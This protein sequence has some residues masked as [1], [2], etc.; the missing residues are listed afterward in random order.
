MKYTRYLR[1]ERAIAASDRGGIIE[2]WR[3]GTRV[4]NDPKM[5]TPNGNLRHGKLAELTAEAKADGHDAA[6]REFQRRLQCARAYRSDAEIR[7]AA[8][9]FP[10]WSDLYDAGFPPVQV[11]LDADTEPFD[12]RDPDEKRRDAARDLA[13]RSQEA[14]GQLALFP[15]DRYGELS[16]L[17]ELAK[18]A[19][20]MAEITERF[21]RK[22]RERADYLKSLIDAVDGDMSKTWAEA[23]AVLDVLGGAE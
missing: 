22:D 14:A 19:T 9:T 21:A 1:L 15:D 7:R 3:W 16:T 23:Q 2:R 11:P 12:P 10:N 13:Q 17:A 20:E 6:Q 18:Y 4:L 5:V 8:D